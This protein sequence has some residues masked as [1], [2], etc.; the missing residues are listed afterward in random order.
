ASL[1]AQVK[2]DGIERGL[3]ALYGEL[4]R[5]QRFGFTATE[6]DRQKQ[7]RTRNFERIVAEQQN[8]VSASRADEYVRNFLFNESLPTADTEFAMNQ[9]FLSEITLDEIN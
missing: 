9:R 3:D 2:E 8:R 7:S 1:F 5:V 6:L 4:A